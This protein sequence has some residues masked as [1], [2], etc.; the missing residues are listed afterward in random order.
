MWSRMYLIFNLTKEDIV[1]VRLEYG[2]RVGIMQGLKKSS[3][4][5]WYFIN[6]VINHY[7]FTLS[8]LNIYN[9]IYLSM[10]KAM[11]S[12]HFIWEIGKTDHPNQI[13]V[14]PLAFSKEG[15]NSW[16]WSLTPYCRRILLG[17]LAALVHYGRYKT[18]FSVNCLSWECQTQLKVQAVGVR[19]SA[20]W[21]ES[22]RL[23]D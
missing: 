17:S 5:K 21:A 18:D 1:R 7:L 2:A 6:K 10:S 14:E 8:L 19:L 13:M 12:K 22:A 3:T 23:A 15:I 20:L 9:P 16:K 11:I 4:H